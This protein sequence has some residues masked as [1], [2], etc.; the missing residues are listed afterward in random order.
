MKFQIQSSSGAK[1]VIGFYLS[2]N[3]RLDLLYS[4]LNLGVLNSLGSQEVIETWNIVH[5]FCFSEFKELKTPNS[6]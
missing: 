4:D 6:C 2:S 1:E 5:P 3:A